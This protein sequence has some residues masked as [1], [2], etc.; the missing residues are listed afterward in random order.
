MTLIKNLTLAG[1]MLSAPAS[2]YDIQHLEPLSW[3]VGM[4]NPELQLM[5][6]GDDIGQLTPVIDYPGVTL[7]AIHRVEN[8]N[9]LFVDLT[10]DEQTQPGSLTI[11]FNRDG[12]TELSYDYPLNSRRDGSA[13]REGFG[14]EDVI[15][16]IT[17][18]RFAN[19]NTDNDSVE[20]MKEPINREYKGGRHGGDLEGIIQHLDYLESLGV[21]QMWLNPVLENDMDRYSYHGYS[22][23]DYYRIDPRY[24]SNEDYRRLSR[25]AQKHGVGLV[26]DI[27]LNHIGSEHYWMEDMPTPDWINHGGEFVETTHRREALHDP[28]AVESDVKAFTDGWFVKTMPDLNQRNPFLANY[29]IQNSIWWVEYADLTGIRLDTYSYPDKGFLSDYTRRVMAEYPDLGLVG[30]EWS[31][32]PAIVAYWQ[33]GTERHDDYQSYIP[34]M[35]DFPLQNA[36][37]NALNN[38][39]TWGTGLRELYQSIANDFLY[40]NPYQLGIFADNHDMTRIYTALNEDYALYKMAMKYILT[41]RGIPQLFYG[42]EI[43]MSHPGTDDHTIIRSDFPGGWQDDKS[44]AFTGDGLTEQQLN[45]Q[46]L[47]TDIL[48]WRQTASA[49]HNGKLTHYAPT[50][51]TYTYFRHNDEQT[52]MVILNKNDE[53]VTVDTGRFHEVIGDKTTARPV[54]GGEPVALDQ[55]I[56]IQAKSARIFEVE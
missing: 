22:T 47:V 45:A 46:S 55:G 25:Q 10:I 14:P 43:L 9:Y 12:Q 36:L 37:V 5:I 52:V 3:W 2:A 11:D 54:L 19:G 16:L 17:P 39:E 23:T 18:D 48:N 20:A 41:T 24:G 13:Q 40:G 51:G 42:T 28:H 56:V 27:I 34:S 30:E 49:I 50:D 4:Q 53:S 29:L 7:D 15:Y 1:V 38:E 44:N 21:T 33:K 6:H 35:F 31:H 32:N 8:D 26:K